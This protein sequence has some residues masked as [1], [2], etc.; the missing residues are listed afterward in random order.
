MFPIERGWERADD[1]E[2]ACL[3]ITVDGSPLTGTV[4][5]SGR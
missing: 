4:E 5:G 1:R 2:Y 3:A